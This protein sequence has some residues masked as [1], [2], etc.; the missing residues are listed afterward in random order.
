MSVWD[1]FMEYAVSFITDVMNSVSEDFAGAFARNQLRPLLKV[2]NPYGGVSADAAWTSIFEISIVLLPILV[3]ASLIV[4]PFSD[5][6]EGGLMGMVVRLVV[7][8]LFIGISQPAWAFAIDA[9]NA[10]TLAILDAPIAHGGDI[11]IFEHPELQE[12]TWKLKVATSLVSVVFVAISLILT[13]FLLLMRWYIVWLVY[14]GT[15][16]F[17]VL[18]FAGRG[19]LESVGNFA[20]TFL[21]MGVYA[22]LA[23]PV[24][25]LIV[26]VFSV[27][28]AGGLVQTAEGY[29]ALLAF[30][31]QLC[32]TFLFPFMLA[33]VTWKM[34][35]WAGQPIGAGEAAAAGTLTAGALATAAVGG[36]ATLATGGTGGVAGGGAAAAGGGA[37]AAGS[38]GAAA[39]GSGGVAA[40]GSSGAAAA[41]SSGAAGASSAG[42]LSG[43]L[44]ALAN[45][46]AGK[47]ANAVG[48]KIASANPYGGL[49]GKFQAAS[50]KLETANAD[51]ATAG[52][53]ADVLDGAT[54]GK[55][56]DLGKAHETGLLPSAP[57]E[58]AEADIQTDEESG[59]LMASYTGEDGNQHSVDLT[60]KRQEVDTNQRDAESRRSE[61]K[62]AKADISNK[63]FTR[64]QRATAAAGAVA[65]GGGQVGK[66]GGKAAAKVS[67]VGAKASLTAMK[68]G[69]GGMVGASMGNPYL[70]YSFSQR[71]R[72]KLITSNKKDEVEEYGK[73]T[74]GKPGNGEG[75]SHHGRDGG[76]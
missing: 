3:A 6:R 53:Q 26:M 44:G 14:I 58:D 5:E 57:A 69:A 29:S 70:S 30:L 7:V 59:A 4:W 22:L 20:G 61:A 43:K 66:K 75:E 39:A 76:F 50:D 10:V 28:E 15:P 16:F 35:S 73:A 31:I 36:V 33:V 74:G 46:G 27:I 63:A 68:I 1:G 48:N 23:G 64:P 19:P 60:E 45:S 67:K 71:G 11:G 62:A 42:G 2:Q 38:G 72:K 12:A 18:W 25:A 41:G 37:A 51:L 21:R 55:S 47:T 56:L 24:I 65:R 8:L 9:T 34:I 54:P 13:L 40:A 49:Q 52:E 32:L 17:A